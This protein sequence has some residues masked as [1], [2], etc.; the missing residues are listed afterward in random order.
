MIQATTVVV[1]LDGDN[2][3][4][5]RALIREEVALEVAIEI[6]RR[7][8]ETV[9]QTGKTVRLI[10][11]M[12]PRAIISDKKLWPKKSLNESERKRRE[13]ITKVDLVDGSKGVCL[14]W[15]LLNL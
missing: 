6:V 7:V 1:N 13:M 12:T 5:V 10:R 14:S 11:A 9:P 15:F 3:D 8:V 4:R 2:P